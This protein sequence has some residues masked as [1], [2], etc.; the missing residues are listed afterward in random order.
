MWPELATVVAGTDGPNPWATRRFD[1]G[2]HGAAD[3]VEVEAVEDDLQHRIDALRQCG[4][5]Q[6]PQRRTVLLVGRG[7]HSLVAG[8][9]LAAASHDPAGEGEDHVGCAI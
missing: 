5:G 3:A 6:S 4:R 2:A 8:A 7:N 1:P 9:H